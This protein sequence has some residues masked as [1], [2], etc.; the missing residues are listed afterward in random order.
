MGYH[1]QGPKL[2][3]MVAEDDDESAFHVED[4]IHSA[5]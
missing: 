4:L 2:H 1:V 5:T 3:W